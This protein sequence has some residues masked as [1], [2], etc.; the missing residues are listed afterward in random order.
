MTLIVKR[1]TFKVIQISQVSVFPFIGKDDVPC[2]L[3]QF[4]LDALRNIPKE[5]NNNLSYIFTFS[6]IC[7][8]LSQFPF[9][10]ISISY[11]WIYNNSPFIV[12]FS[13]FITFSSSSIYG[14]SCSSFSQLQVYFMEF[15]LYFSQLQV[16]FSQFRFYFHNCNFISFL[17]LFFLYLLTS[18]LRRFWAS[19]ADSRPKLAPIQPGIASIWVVAYFKY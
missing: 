7:S 5:F 13:F 15:W 8:V 4:I 12:P 3:R 9:S 16:Y 17:W 6:F 10:G 1:A 11:I 2:Q 19:S 18:V 14:S